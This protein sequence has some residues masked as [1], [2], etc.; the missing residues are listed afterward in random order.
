LFAPIS[1][2]SDGALLGIRYIDFKMEVV[3]IDIPTG[4][5]TNL[6]AKID[7]KDEFFFG[8]TSTTDGKGTYY[9]ALML[10]SGSQIVVV[11][12]ETGKTKKQVAV[13]GNYYLLEYDPTSG[14][15]LWLGVDF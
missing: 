14:D 2:A 5:I 7:P 1:S 6:G 9:V 12:A 4:K 3:T 13:T 15:V 11:D 10:G 8:A